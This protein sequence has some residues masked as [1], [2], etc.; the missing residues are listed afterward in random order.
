MISMCGVLV[1][2][3]NIFI[4]LLDCISRVWLLFMCVSV[5]MM[6]LKFF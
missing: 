5:L 3:W 1:W 4:G 6:V 2:V